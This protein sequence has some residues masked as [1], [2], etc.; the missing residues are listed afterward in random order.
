MKILWLDLKKMEVREQLRRVGV[1]IV[2]KKRAG[3]S[4]N[5]YEPQG[6]LFDLEKAR[7]LAEDNPA[8]KAALEEAQ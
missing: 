3:R 1:A 6:L 7:K 8:I 2:G 5:E 4:N